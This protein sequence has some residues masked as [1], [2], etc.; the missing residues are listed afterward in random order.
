MGNKYRPDQ[1]DLISVINDLKDRVAKLER[2][3]RAPSTAVDR[4]DWSFVADNGVELV[5]FGEVII[6]SGT[7][8]WVFRRGNNGTNA[9][10]LGGAQ[11]GNQYFALLD[12]SANTI[13]SDDA[14]SQQGLARPYLTM[15][16]TKT[17]EFQN[18]A[19]TTTLGTF[20]SAYHISGLKQHP[21]FISNYVATTPAGVTMQVQVVDQSNAGVVIAGPETVPA[22]SFGF[23]N[24]GGP[25]AI[26]G[27]H[28]SGI[29]LDIQI[30][31]ASGAGTV[32]ITHTDTYGRQT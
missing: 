27:V 31:V 24:F 11:S 1:A 14:A 19:F 32:G 3:P 16:V 10:F 12:N 18:P 29:N 5:K 7:R 6:G 13:I 23:F 28:M 15:P 4:G 30:R 2:V 17:V 22:S 20:Q 9:L 26:A 21:F 8:G 25:Y